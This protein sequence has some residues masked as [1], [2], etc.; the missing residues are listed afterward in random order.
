[1]VIEL[2][3]LKDDYSNCKLC[4][5]LVQ[6]R[7]KVV[8]GSKHMKQCPIMIIGE[9][10][11]KKEDELGEPF[12]GKSGEILN[13]FLEEIG[14][15]R[16]DVF[17]TNTILCRPKD[18]RNPKTDE[19]KNCSSRLNKVI[20]L[21]NPKVIITLGNF[22]TKYILKTDEGITKLRGKIYEKDGRKI[23]PMPHPATLLYAGMSDILMG[24]FRSDFKLVKSLIE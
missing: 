2:N 8:F 9:A 11:G 18:N 19:L 14:L 21:I 12:V 16:G 20:E 5:E 7:S 6:S 3:Q 24:Q 23:L 15:T 17:I 4:N 22:S 10:P 1:M 13:R